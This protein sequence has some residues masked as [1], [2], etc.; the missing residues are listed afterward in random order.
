MNAVAIS[1]H[2]SV[3]EQPPGGGELLDADD[4][5]ALR[6]PRLDPTGCRP[7]TA[8]RAAARSRQEDLGLVAEVQVVE[9][10]GTPVQ[11]RLG[12]HAGVVR[13]GEVTRRLVDREVRPQE[14][15]AVVVDVADAPLQPVSRAD[16]P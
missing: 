2:S 11:A 13:F 15:A 1:R 7:S 10:L 16:V 4:V 8:R 12:A 9:I 6:R 5:A 3:A 14:L